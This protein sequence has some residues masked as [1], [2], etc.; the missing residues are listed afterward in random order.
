MMKLLYSVNEAQE[1]LGLGRSLLLKLV[2]SGEIESIK[3]GSRR[4]IPVEA[5]NEYVQRQ[6]EALTNLPA[7]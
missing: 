2:Y 1:V 3:V 5:L 7:R 4:L 6:R